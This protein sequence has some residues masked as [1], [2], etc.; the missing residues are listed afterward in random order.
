MKRKFISKFDPLY[1]NNEDYMVNP[2][3]MNNSYMM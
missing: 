3:N 2:L 1:K